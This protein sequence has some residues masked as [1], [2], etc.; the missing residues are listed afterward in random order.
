MSTGNTPKVELT[1]KEKEVLTLIGQGLTSQE[2][3]E[4]LFV[5]KR[6]I[7]FHLANI[8]Q[9]FGVSN[10]MKA[11]NRAVSMGLINLSVAV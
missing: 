11:Y 5:S 8:F 4:R 1:R 2:A 9:K 3:A 10:R 7:D 6:T